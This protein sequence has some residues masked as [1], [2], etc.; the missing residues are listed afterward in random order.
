MLV[1]GNNLTCLCSADLV[2][3]SG[4][5][6]HSDGPTASRARFTL[7]QVVPVAVGR[8]VQISCDGLPRFT[9]RITDVDTEPAALS[10]DAP[11]TVRVDAVGRLSELGRALT[12]WFPGTTVWPQESAQD[13]VGRIVAASAT[14]VQVL[15]RGG[16]PDM[17]PYDDGPVMALQAITDVA[18]DVGAAVLDLPDGRVLWQAYDARDALSVP[19]SWDEAVGDWDTFHDGSWASITQESVVA[20]RNVRLDPC[21]VEWAPQ[22]GQS[23]GDIVNWVK[24]DYGDPAA[25]VYRDDRASIDLYGPEMSTLGTKLAV[26]ADAEQRARSIILRRGAPRWDVRRVDIDLFACTES[27]SAEYRSLRVGDRVT[28]PSLPA[29]SPGGQFVGDR[30]EWV[31]VLEGWSEEHS[32]DTWLMRLHLSNPALS[33]NALTWE[34]AGDGTW[35]GQPAG[36]EWRR[37][38]TLVSSTTEEAA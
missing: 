36:L 28:V 20:P 32:A 33:I 13:R 6:D 5:K 8:V 14:G 24:V 22:W 18:A 35:A 11:N 37:W 25:M 9:G 27:Q 7:T 1:D 4:R 12:A 15:I 19:V 23:R 31:G 38:D 21:V 2:I 30:R 3:E 29:A 16:L 26:K 10:H 17:L 34:Q